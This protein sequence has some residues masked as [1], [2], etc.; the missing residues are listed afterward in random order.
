MRRNRTES[1]IP[2]SIKRFHQRGLW[3]NE[4]WQKEFETAVAFCANSRNVDGCLRRIAGDF[5][6]RRC[7]SA[8]REASSDHASHAG[9]GCQT[10]G[11]TYAEKPISN[12]K[13]IGC[14]CAD[15]NSDSF[16]GYERWQAQ[17]R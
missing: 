1:S 4:V 5:A 2:A 7:T 9:G 16:S 17:A 6:K 3:R 10:N 11:N 8:R 13:Y 14:S 12:S 15:G